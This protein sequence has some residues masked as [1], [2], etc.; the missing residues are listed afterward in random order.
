VERVAV[1][2]RGQVP[3]GCH[4][5][6]DSGDRLPAAS[7]RAEEKEASAYGRK[8]HAGGVESEWEKTA[9]DGEKKDEIGSHRDLSI[10]FDFI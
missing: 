4:E 1:D 5:R 8:P 7:T 6:E 2:L 3:I 9:Q 10:S